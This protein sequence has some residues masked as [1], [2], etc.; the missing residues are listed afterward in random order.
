[1]YIYLQIINSSLYSKSFMEILIISDLF[2]FS[3]LARIQ[4]NNHPVLFFSLLPALWAGDFK[5]VQ[6][7][8][9]QNVS[10]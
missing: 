1:M 6:I 5:A 7:P 10:L 8:K 3:F 9:S 4:G 2:F